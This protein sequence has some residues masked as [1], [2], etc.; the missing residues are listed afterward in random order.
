MQNNFFIWLQL[1][2]DVKDTGT[3]VQIR[4]LSTIS[5]VLAATGHVFRTKWKWYWKDE[6][7]KWQSYDNEKTSTSSEKIE[8]QYQSG[9]YM[10]I[11]K[12]LIRSSHYGPRM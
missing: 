5:S 6:H 12:V 2:C 3:Q 9:T 1:D 7:D 8:Q 10:Y 11:C 4:R